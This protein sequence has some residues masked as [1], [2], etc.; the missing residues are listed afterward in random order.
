MTKAFASLVGLFFLISTPTK[1]QIIDSFNKQVDG[2]YIGGKYK[3]S[4]H[5][6]NL[7]RPSIT[8]HDTV[9]YSA[10][11]FV[12]VLEN[13]REG[14]TIFIPGDMVF[15]LTG[16][17]KIKIPRGVTIYS[18]RG[19]NKSEGALLRTNDISASPLFYTDGANIKISGLRILGP[20]S[21]IVNSVEIDKM[22]VER[23]SI[24]EKVDVKNINPTYAVPN[25][26]FL[27]V[28]YDNV[29]IENCEIYGW[30]YAGVFVRK[31]GS[32]IVH[33]CYIHHNRRTGLG[34]GIALDAGHAD[35]T[36]NIFSFNRHAV[37]GTGVRGT[38]Y[39]ASH[40]IALSNSNGHVFDMHGGRNRKDGTNLAGDSVII[41]NNLFFTNQYRPFVLSGVSF[42]KSKVSKNYIVLT[43]KEFVEVPNLKRLGRVGEKNIR[44][45]FAQIND[46]GNLEITDNMILK[47]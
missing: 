17:R 31:N 6:Y 7:F 18:D 42:Y 27:H 46:G 15:D 4:I 36:A 9:V 11:A 20:D 32:A 16:K 43:D 28:Y 22:L 35:V 34:Y 39:V 23:K 29:E 40:N 10:E 33:H 12:D 44:R 41:F 24:G 30:S 13:A 25:S 3:G 47:E 5:E 14:L 45:Y 19:Q 26:S 8:D 1:G 38:S 2:N 21:T 37:A